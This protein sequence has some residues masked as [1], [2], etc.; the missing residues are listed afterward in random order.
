MSDRPKN[1]ERH[2]KDTKNPF[3]ELVLR[4]ATRNRVHQQIIP[5]GRPAF[6]DLR[7]MVKKEREYVEGKAVI[8]EL[9]KDMLIVNEDILP[10][11]NGL[12][13]ELRQ[14][15]AIPGFSVI[16]SGSN[17]HGGA[18]I[19]KVANTQESADFDFA[20]SADDLVKLN[21]EQELIRLFVKRFIDQKKKLYHLSESFHS[22]EKYDGSNIRGNFLDSTSAKNELLSQVRNSTSPWLVNDVGFMVYF[23][24]SSPPE[25]G[26]KNRQYILEALRIIYREDEIEWRMVR[27]YLIENW[28]EQHI[29]KSKHLYDQAYLTKTVSKISPWTGSQSPSEIRLLNRLEKT[30]SE[31]MVGP[32]I[33]LIDSTKN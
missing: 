5:R 30:S 32:F 2:G 3:R 4:L 26:E 8:S 29:L 18:E 16:I 23:Y 33:R 31:A 19:R 13:S 11:V 22:C 17:V 20:L 6:G 1:R 25:I 9:T 14:Q 27:N 28:K 15:F 7:K 24:P 10:F 21:H 12:S